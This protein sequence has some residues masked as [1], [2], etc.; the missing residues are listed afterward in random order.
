MQSSLSLLLLAAMLAGCADFPESRF[1]RSSSRRDGGQAP[2]AGHSRGDGA[3]A[4]SRD[5]TAGRLDSATRSPDTPSCPAAC[6]S[7]TAGQ[8]QLRCGRKTCRCPAG[9][10]CAIDCGG[11]DCTGKIDCRAAAS[12][13][14]RCRDASCGKI[15]CGPGR[16]S[17][18]CSGRACRSKI[19]CGERASC[20]IDCSGNA[21][22]DD[23]DCDDACSCRVRC[24]GNAC[25]HVKCID[26][27]CRAGSGCALVP[28]ADCNTCR[29]R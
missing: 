20:D 24:R 10:H 22:T 12:C 1:S 6:Q 4:A 17:I 13:T 8:C 21:C 18:T 11:S 23:I 3:V 26:K 2:G 29:S 25:H 15:E 27:A 28:A 19:R 5:A 7:C 14:I 9:M 16:C